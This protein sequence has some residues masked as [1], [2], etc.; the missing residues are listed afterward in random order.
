MSNIKQNVR[1]LIAKDRSL[2]DS[3]NR[4]I[5]TYWHEIIFINSDNVLNTFFDTWFCDNTKLCNTITRHR[6]IIEAENP[7]LRGKTYKARHHLEKEVR[8]KIKKGTF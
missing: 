5:F 7:K 4:L 2:A 8:E 3:D 6:R 1:Q